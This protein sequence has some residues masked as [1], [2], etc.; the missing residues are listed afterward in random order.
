MYDG[1]HS[2]FYTFNETASF[3]FGKLKLGVPEQEIIQGL[4]KLYSIKAERAEKD[5]NELVTDL[6]KKKIISVLLSKRPN[7]SLMG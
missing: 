2:L 3:I 7:K 5:F 1:E 4:T 6:K